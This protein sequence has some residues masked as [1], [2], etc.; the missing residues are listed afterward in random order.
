[1]NNF[2]A[3]IPIA[4]ISA[5]VQVVFFSYYWNKLWYDP[6]FSDDGL[7]ISTI[8]GGVKLETYVFE[9]GSFYNVHWVPFLSAIAVVQQISNLDPAVIFAGYMAFTHVISVWVI[10]NILGGK[11]V[12]I[13]ENHRNSYLVWC[14]ALIV[15]P[16]V[17]AA[18][19]SLTYPHFEYFPIVL[20]AFLLTLGRDRKYLFLAM[21]IFASTREDYAFLAGAAMIVFS[22][23]KVGRKSTEFWFGCVLVLYSAIGFCIRFLTSGYGSVVTS[24]SA[25]TSAIK[26][27]ENVRQLFGS[28][29]AALYILP[30]GWSIWCLAMNRREEDLAIAASLSSHSVEVERSLTRSDLGLFLGLATIVTSFFAGIPQVSRLEMHYGA[31]LYLATIL[32]CTTPGFK[33]RRIPMFGISMV[34]VIILV[35]WRFEPL[36]AQKLINPERLAEVKSELLVL[37]E[38]GAILHTSVVVLDPKQYTESQIFKGTELAGICVIINPH[39]SFIEENLILAYDNSPEIFPTIAPLSAVGDCEYIDALSAR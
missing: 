31:P 16:F 8:S 7:F 17:S 22:L 20:A 6:Y 3:W 19:I 9:Y 38:Q 34:A 15:G 13:R 2:R 10:R 33:A 30:F 23:R 32:V 39:S 25:P 1:M 37:T 27:S 11:T 28:Y 14:T 35:P 4:L 24:L 21:V 26:L 12:L 18:G 36:V 29:T 5:L